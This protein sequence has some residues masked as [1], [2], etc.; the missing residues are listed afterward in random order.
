VTGKYGALTLNYDGKFSYVIDDGI[1]EVDALRQAGDTLIDVF[2]YTMSD[3]LGARTSSTLT[4]TITGSNDAP[5]AAD[6]TGFVSKL[7][8]LSVT[9]ENG[10]LLN[11][12]DVDSG[13]ALSVSAIAQGGTSQ[14]VTA[15]TPGMLVSAMGQLT[16]N[17][18][19]SYTYLANGTVSANLAAGVTAIDTFSYTVT[20]LAGATAA[21]VL[22]ITVTGSANTDPVALPDMGTAIEGGAAAGTTASGNVLTNDSDADTGD[23]LS[24]DSI[25]GTAAGSVGGVTTGA[26]G[27]LTLNADGSYSYVIN[28]ADTVVNALSGPAQTLTDVFTYVVKD[29]ANAS[30]MATLTITIQGA[31]DAPTVQADAASA[32]EAGTTA[33]S[34]ATGNVLT[35]DSDA[36]NGDSVAIHS[37]AGIAAGTVGGTTAG[38]YG[39]LTL[40]A[41]GSYSYVV[42]DA[43]AAVNALS[44]PS[45][46]L[47]DVFTYVLR[48]LSNAQSTATLTITIHGAND[49]PVAAADTA[50]AIPDGV[51]AGSSA[52]GNV[53]S[54][55]TD[56]DA[57][58]SFSVTGVTNGSNGTLNG[59]TAGLYGNLT[60]NSDGTYS[61]AVDS[62]N[63]TVRALY[64]DTLTDVFTYT[65]SD[66]PGA[67]SSSTV[68]IKI[69]GADDAP[70]L[71]S[72]L[73]DQTGKLNEALA[74]LNV[75]ANF[76]PVDAGDPLTYSLSNAPAWLSIDPAT[77]IISGTP[78][79]AGAYDITVVAKDG[80]A[81]VAQ[82][83]YKLT[84][85]SE[86][87]TLLASQPLSGEKSLDV[88]SPLVL[89][90]SEDISLGSGQIRI[91]DDMGTSGFV[92]QQYNVVP[93]ASMQD[94]YDNDV[95]LT[96]DKGVITG[97]TIGGIDKFTEVGASVSV[98][99]SMLIINPSG[100]HSAAA[101]TAWN[102]DWDFGAKYHI[103]L[104]AGVVTG[105]ATGT[106]NEAIVSATALA[107][108][109]VAPN[110]NG[111]AT[112]SYK[113]NVISGA[114]ESSYF[115]HNGHLEKDGVG[116][117]TLLDFGNGAHA[118]VVI[119][120]GYPSRNAPMGGEVIIKDFGFS[121]T[122]LTADDLI[123]ND[124]LGDMSMI[125]TEST[126]SGKAAIWGKADLSIG[127]ELNRSLS[128]T[129]NSNHRINFNQT[130]HESFFSSSNGKA[131]TS[132]PIFED[133]THYNANVIVFG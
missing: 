89:K 99:G 4:V 52:T 118:I 30:A 90:F 130:D 20:D 13:D 91:M 80:A 62:L 22:K 88:T 76:D 37:I 57:L 125:T 53:L 8:S 92:V 59:V 27:T 48:D 66:S 49:A 74:P 61:Y 21:A 41:D 104:D 127:D 10:L 114:M 108:T 85:G 117:G 109:T 97:F 25:T 29:L 6:N 129:G 32:D 123:Y 43:H 70:V 100:D 5:L 51:L 34:A 71:A 84:I 122:T 64:Q 46:T 102:F 16:I 56:G 47:T 121:G 119:N 26:Y 3:N 78:A 12:T 77:G 75:A 1:A 73:A 44:D 106:V 7:S 111:S 2:T 55:D 67:I 113:M 96:L 131:I 58:D 23:T 83:I 79:S 45:Q 87:L 18:D 94:K 68:T 112:P 115:W 9:K 133:A 50:T 60:L 124:N 120:Q 86:P 14:P 101:N 128:G 69:Q 40:N 65:L 63:A 31:N 28:E 39:T 38:S 17:Q 98:M 15:G 35:N 132:D 95:V 126:Y 110:Q 93:S 24:M 36:D 103:E 42:N 72:A 54:N 19:G 116:Y 105:T 81:N 107:F 33:G 11:A 82:D